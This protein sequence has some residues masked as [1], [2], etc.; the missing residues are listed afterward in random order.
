MGGSGSACAVSDEHGPAGLPHRE[1][2]NPNKTEIPSLLLR[3]LTSSEMFL[4]TLC[5]DFFTTGATRGSDA[6]HQAIWGSGAL[7]QEKATQRFSKA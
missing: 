1:K 2:P 5:G 6:I 7:R 4:A 3:T